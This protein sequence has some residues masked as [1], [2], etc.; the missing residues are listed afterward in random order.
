MVARRLL[1]SIGCL[2]R[3]TDRTRAL[4]H[5]WKAVLTCDLKVRRIRHS[6]GDV[7][8]GASLQSLLESP[9][10]TGVV[11]GH[12]K[13]DAGFQLSK[14]ISRASYPAYK[15]ELVSSLME[16]IMEHGRSFDVKAV[17]PERTEVETDRIREA[18]L[19]TAIQSDIQ[20][21]VIDWFAASVVA[22]YLTQA[23][24]GWDNAVVDGHYG[25]TLPSDLWLQSLQLTS[26]TLY[27]I[28]AHYNIQFFAELRSLDDEFAKTRTGKVLKTLAGEAFEIQKLMKRVSHLYSISQSLEH[29]F[30]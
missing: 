29:W 17:F 30:D 13:K 21:D 12:Q 28:L 26:Q 23:C 11:A 16:V 1:Q 14:A 3:S 7:M 25:L 10:F 24:L 27:V 18:S 5:L 2:P 19:E 8:P 9:F 6:R 22:L 20:T 15:Q 4:V